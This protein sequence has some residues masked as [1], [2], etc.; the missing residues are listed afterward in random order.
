VLSVGIASVGCLVRSSRTI[1]AVTCTDSGFSAPR[2]TLYTVD[3][4]GAGC[5][6]LSGVD[7]ADEV[8]NGGVPRRVVDSTFG[9]VSRGVVAKNDDLRWVKVELGVFKAVLAGLTGEAESRLVF[10]AS[11]LIL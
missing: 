10:S 9:E 2:C 11:A 3:L 1:R 5:F 7:E 4:T 6:F 8:K